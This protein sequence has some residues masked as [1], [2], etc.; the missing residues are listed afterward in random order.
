MSYVPP[1]RATE[2]I[3]Y[4]RLTSQANPLLFQVNPTLAAGDVKISIDGGAQANLATLPVVTPAGSTRVKVTVSAAEM[5]GD[6]IDI[7]F[8]DAAGAQWCDLGLNI[9]PSVQQID[10]LAS[11][12]VPVT[13]V[14]G[15][16]GG[17][18]VGSVGSVVGAVGSVTG[19]VGSVTGAVGS[20]TG[21]VGGN[22][23]GSV[24]SLATQAKADVN[25]EVVDAINVDTY[26]EVTG[27]PGFPVSLVTMIR[28][29]YATL[30][31]GMLTNST[32]GKKQF[33]NAAGTA[34]WEKDFTSTNNEYDESNG[35]AP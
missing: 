2:F 32:T 29:A 3:T 35:N 11:S 12:T 24:G 23:T 16:V 18:V 1:K 34:E 27:V 26:T 13:S 5:T 33:K 31:N 7:D 4:V 19:A 30:V 9:Q 10:T 21:N 15:N 6:N 25:A 22:V 20:V 8:I 17:N 14:T 28:R